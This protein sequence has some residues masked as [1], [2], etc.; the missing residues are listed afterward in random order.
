[1]KVNI[2]EILVKETID[3]S[4]ICEQEVLRINFED[5]PWPTISFTFP[6]IDM[7]P[8]LY[9]ELDMTVVC[10]QSIN[11]FGY[12]GGGYWNSGMQSF[13]SGERKKLKLFQS[14]SVDENVQKLYPAMRGKPGN[15][16]EYWA[17]G[18]KEANHKH[19]SQITLEA[20]Q[21]HTEA[22][23]TIHSI[24]PAGEV[25][26]PTSELKLKTLPLIDKYGQFTGREWEDKVHQDSDLIQEELLKPI[27]NLD[28][29]GGYIS[30]ISTKATGHFRTELI[31]GNWYLITPLGNLFWSVGVNSIRLE[32]V[33]EQ[34]GREEL[35]ENYPK[36]GCFYANNLKT[37]YGDDYISKAYE[38]IHAR[39][40]SWGV[41]TI[42]N[43]SDE[44]LISIRKTPYTATVS[45]GYD[46]ELGDGRALND[47][48]KKK[49]CEEVIRGAKMFADD[50]LCI[51]VFVD[52][53]IHMD[54]SVDEWEYYYKTVSECLKKYAPNK[55]YL[56]SRLD[57]HRYPR[58][59][60]FRDEILRI[61][62]KY[63]DVVSINQYRYTVANFAL[64]FELSKP[65]LIGEFHFGALDRDGIH[66]G[67]RA[68]E[69]QEQRAEAFS[70]YLNSALNHP[71]M[72][73]A[74]WFEYAT[75]PISGRFDGENYQIGLVD[76]CDI[77]YPKMIDSVREFS[78]TMY[79]KRLNKN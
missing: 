5:A 71:N 17:E 37:K 43:W 26:V 40:A 55:L 48:W 14:R 21:A 24:C 46:R 8:Y 45:S 44:E 63:C 27:E 60:R 42:G 6:E 28:K 32:R 52:N 47:C 36:D 31:N 4:Y 22:F 56:G 10:E 41:N 34:I 9:M 61:A 68:T 50:P 23:I 67:L 79:E 16:Y 69:S 53:E 12:L 11:I 74:H 1:M 20:E 19:L 2:A 38:N 76:I 58:E 64:P 3:S 18:A 77:P 70:Y 66:P 35:F 25:I 15:Y 59:T 72:V 51:G 30:D 78:E 49:L 73:G 33:T 62:C 57:F 75:Q 29:Y 13:K 39:F 65:I 54:F 7:T